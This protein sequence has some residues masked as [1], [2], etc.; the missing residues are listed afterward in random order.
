MILLG[1]GILAHLPHGPQVG[2]YINS[3]M[4]QSSD[5]KQ[6]ANIVKNH[7]FSPTYFHF[8]ISFEPFLKPVPNTKKEIAALN[9]R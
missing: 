9:L 3:L 7:H 6:Y 4:C 5:H 1:T 8:Q 2:S